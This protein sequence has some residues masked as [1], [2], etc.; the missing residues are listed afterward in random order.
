[1]IG[2]KRAFHL[3]LVEPVLLNGI[4]RLKIVLDRVS[5]TL[6]ETLI[7]NNLGPEGERCKIRCLKRYVGHKSL[8]LSTKRLPKAVIMAV[9]REL[10]ERIEVKIVKTQQ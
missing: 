2:Q 9:D 7:R 4:P 6:V 1:M 10:K 3:R 8:V 5:K